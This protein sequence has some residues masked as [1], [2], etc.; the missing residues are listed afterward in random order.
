MC[1]SRFFSFVDP[2]DSESGPQ[3]AEQGPNAYSIERDFGDSID[4]AVFLSTYDATPYR[5]DMPWH[6]F[7]IE[8][9]H[10]EPYVESSGM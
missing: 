5:S 2:N 3:M 6:P 1:D 10:S 9:Q 7:M 8:N 4:P